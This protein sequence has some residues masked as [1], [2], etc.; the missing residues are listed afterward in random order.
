[1]GQGFVC[2]PTRK[3]MSVAVPVDMQDK[4]R[5]PHCTLT[6][7]EAC[8]VS[9]R[10]CYDLDA[11]DVSDEQTGERHLGKGPGERRWMRAINRS[12]QH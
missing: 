6:Q 1:M 12:I 11:S 8:K 7:W 3:E 10:K 2:S 4:V 5:S 9:T